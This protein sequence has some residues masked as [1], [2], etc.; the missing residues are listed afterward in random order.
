MPE[1]ITGFDSW[2]QIADVQYEFRFVRHYENSTIINFSSVEEVFLRYGPEDS[3]RLWPPAAWRSLLRRYR[4]RAPLRFRCES[5][6]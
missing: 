4:A 2:F 3:S 5:R 6:S 1:K